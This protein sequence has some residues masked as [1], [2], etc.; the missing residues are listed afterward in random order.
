[1]TGTPRAALTPTSFHSSSSTSRS[2]RTVQTSWLWLLRPASSAPARSA[3][4]FNAWVEAV[5]AMQQ[6][7]SA[8]ANTTTATSIL[9]ATGKWTFNPFFFT[10]GRAL[11]WTASGRISNIVTT[12]GTLTLDF[13]L[14]STV[15]VNGGA[16][17]L[18]TT[19]KTNVSWKSTGVITCRAVGSGTATTFLGQGEFASESVVGSAAGVAGQISMPASAPAVGTG[20]DYTA[21]QTLD[22][23]ATWS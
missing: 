23:F 13:R 7:G 6:D 21:S 10:T 18:N 8:L 1:M 9:H 15:I 14:G 19:A 5:Q 17:A 2:H 11:R 12:P 20:I 4:S 3:M 16:M 22:M